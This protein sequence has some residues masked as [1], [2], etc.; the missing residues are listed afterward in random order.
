M[1]KTAT[2]CDI[3]TDAMHVIGHHEVEN[4]TIVSSFVMN[5]LSYT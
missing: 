5:I 3:L 2:T 4:W 1:D